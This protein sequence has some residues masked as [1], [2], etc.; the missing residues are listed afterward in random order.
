MT[1]KGKDFLE[2]LCSQKGPFCALPSHFISSAGQPKLAL[3][4]RAKEK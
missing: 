3:V 1:G 4:V 2:Y